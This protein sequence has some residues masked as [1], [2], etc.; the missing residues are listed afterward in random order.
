MAPDGGFDLIVLDV[1]LPDKDGVAVCHE[2]RQSGVNTPVLILTV[3]DALEDRV[4]GFAAGADDYIAKSCE[5]VE[6]IARIKAIVRRSQSSPPV[7]TKIGHSYEFGDV[8]VDIPRAAVYR[9]NDRVSLSAMEYELLRFSSC[10]PAKSCREAGYWRRFGWVRQRPNRERS[11]FMSP[12]CGRNRG[13]L[14]VSALDPDRS[15]SGLQVPARRAGTPGGKLVATAGSDMARLGQS[16]DESGLAGTGVS[17]R[18]GSGGTAVRQRDPPVRT[19]RV[20][21]GVGSGG[22]S[23]RQ[24]LAEAG[25]SLVVVQRADLA[26]AGTGRS[27]PWGGRRV[28]GV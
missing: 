16:R 8:R 13:K 17:L 4:R 7:N 5:F 21:G 26:T 3:R 11:M 24:V 15:R 18:S 12:A 9:G 1:I 22:G 27:P 25:F 14:G 10:M 23:C 6:L 20:I 28:D 19:R 2:L